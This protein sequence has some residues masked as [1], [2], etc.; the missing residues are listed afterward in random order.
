MQQLYPLFHTDQPKS[1]AL[2]RLSRIEA[3]ALIGDTQL[4]GAVNADQ[5]HYGAPSARMPCDVTQ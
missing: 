1:V 4:D 5:R 2:P 3:D